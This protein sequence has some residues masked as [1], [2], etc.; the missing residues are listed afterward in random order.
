MVAVCVVRQ[1]W[2]PGTIVGISPRSFHQDVHTSSKPAPTDGRYQDE[3]PH[4]YRKS[5][6]T[7]SAIY[8]L[9]LRRQCA[10]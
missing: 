5:A 9:M 8:F 2:L 4:A 10:I 1:T 6:A 3:G 7:I